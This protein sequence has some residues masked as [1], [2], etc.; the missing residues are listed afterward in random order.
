[1]TSTRR[2]AARS[3]SGTRATAATRRQPPDTDVII[4]GAGAAG[5]AAANVLTEGGA[6]CVVLEARGRTGGRIHTEWAPGCAAPIELG[7]EFIHGSASPIQRLAERYRLRALD[8]AGDRFER[9]GTRLT[10]VRDMW[11]RIDRVMRCLDPRRDPDRSLADALRAS[12][13]RLSAAD[14]ALATRFFEGFDAADP[15]VV[16]ERWLASMPS[17]AHDMRE[18]RVGRLVDGYGS[19]IDA[20]ARSIRERVRLDTTVSVVR[21]RRGHVEVVYHTG[22]N[23]RRGWLTARAILITVPLGVLQAPV[24][25]TGAIRFDPAVPALDRASASG[26]MGP[27]VKVV[28]H[29]AHPFWLEPRVTQRLGVETLD[30]MSFMQSRSPLPFG[31]WWTAYPVRAPV[32]V[33]WAGGPRAAALAG[34]PAAELEHR[35]V[36]SLAAMLSTTAAR[37]RKHLVASHY[38]DWCGDPFSRGAYSYARVGGYRMSALL[39]RPIQQTIWYAGEAADHAASTGTVHGAIA[40]GERAA[41]RILTSR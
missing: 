5:L 33:A 29:F 24:G 14:R 10:V 41:R 25:S 7:A 17:P 12:R 11:A 9:S 32:F 23:A 15:R 31:V 28:L 3:R 35:A 22:P 20:L 16:S 26:V 38:H 19:L 1:M 36:Q 27:V 37:V 8:I 34:L 30:R 4:V 6:E 13:G 21:W 40:S 18:A 2:A 39:A